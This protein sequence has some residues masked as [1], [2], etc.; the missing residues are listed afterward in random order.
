[1]LYLGDG[2]SRDGAIRPVF[3]ISRLDDAVVLRQVIR[4]F[5]RLGGTQQLDQVGTERTSRQR[6]RA[7]QPAAISHPVH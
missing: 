2:R 1:M 6:D 4:V 3:P 5:D 7:N